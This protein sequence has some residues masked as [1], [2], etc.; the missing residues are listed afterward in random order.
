L[1]TYELMNTTAIL[2][3]AKICV[4]IYQYDIQKN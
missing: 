2:K 3:S 1:P 4:P